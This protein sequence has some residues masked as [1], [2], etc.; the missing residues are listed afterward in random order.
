[1]SVGN[2]NHGK[3]LSEFDRMDTDTLEG[4]LRADLEKPESEQLDVDTVIYIT[5]I[6]AERR[7]NDP[8]YVPVDVDKAWAEFT[9]KYL[10]YHSNGHSLY[11]DEDDIDLTPSVAAPASGKPKRHIIRWIGTAAAALCVLLLAGT[12]AASALGYDVWGTV[13]KWTSETFQLIR[14][15]A[16]G[17]ST[18]P[19]IIDW[20]F[21]SLE[22]AL[23]DY[24]LEPNGLVPTWL[25]EGYKFDSIKIDETPTSI[26]F[27]AKYKNGVQWL[28][29]DIKYFDDNSA[30]IHERDILNAE[31]Y[32]VNESNYYIFS[33]E[34]NE[35]VV[36]AT[37]SCEC[38]LIYDLPKTDLY[39]IIDSIHRE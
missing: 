33:N 25:P 19:S 20:E 14:P 26:R 34:D 11:D 32:Q 29:V 21:S 4:I 37:D 13:T 31:V 10:P 38:S 1:M 23:T 24:G 6:L 39:Q 7:K 8:S 16:D 28:W 15:S 35:T 9:E 36:W 30:S 27:L 3:G 5:E 12:A 22:T 17:E 18:P 2:P